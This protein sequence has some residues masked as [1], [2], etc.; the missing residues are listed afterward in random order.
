[1][2]GIIALEVHFFT[3]SIHTLVK[4]VSLDYCISGNS[5]PVIIYSPSPCRN[6]FDSLTS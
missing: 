2:A 4:S 5:V 6:K 3:F 1:M